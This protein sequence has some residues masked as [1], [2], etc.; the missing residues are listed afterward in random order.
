MEKPVGVVLVRERAQIV[1]L[2]LVSNGG[3]RIRS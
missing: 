2:G 1:D 3:E